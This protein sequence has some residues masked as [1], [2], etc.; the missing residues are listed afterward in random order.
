MVLHPRPV[1]LPP[2]QRNEWECGIAAIRYLMLLL[3]H[4]TERWINQAIGIAGTTK[5]DGTSH[6][7][8]MQ[9]I[10]WIGYKPV[11]QYCQIQDVPVPSI[12][13]YQWNGDGHYG[14]LVSKTRRHCF[15]FNPYDGEIDRWRLWDFNDAFF[16]KRYGKL[17]S[18]SVKSIP[19][20]QSPH[21]A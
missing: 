18:V 10:A 7:G 17:W 6:A 9:V 13:N 20:P 4:D 19:S 14:V 1:I 5:K 3:N 21:T 15:I 16:S 11:E 2:T 8:I 12:V